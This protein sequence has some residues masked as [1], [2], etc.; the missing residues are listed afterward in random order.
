MC[1]Y[2]PATTYDNKLLTCV[3]IKDYRPV[4][5]KLW[6]Y[7]QQPVNIDMWLVTREYFKH[8]AGNEKIVGRNVFLHYCNDERQQTVEHV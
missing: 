4:D 3:N 2:I 5:M 1:F 8:V 7:P 6:C